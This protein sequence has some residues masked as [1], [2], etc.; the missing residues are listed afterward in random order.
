[1]NFDEIRSL[2]QA[3]LERRLKELP[4]EIRSWRAL[5]SST[6]V[7][8][9]GIHTSQIMALGDMM[10]GL[11]ARQQ[12]RFAELRNKEAQSDFADAYY[13]LLNDV[14]G[15]HDLWRIFRI[16]LDQRQNARLK[17]LADVSDLVAQ[18]CYLTALRR[19]LGWG[20]IAA[21]EFRPPPLT[22][23]E[24]SLTPATASRGETIETLGFSVRQYR[25]LMLPLP[26]VL[27]PVDQAASMWSMSSIAHE[28]GHNLDHDLAPRQGKRLSD[29]FRKLLIGLVD[30][31][32]EPQWRRW[33]NEIFA[34][35]VA[36][37][38]CGSGYVTC[39]ANWVI[40]L[41][42]G[43]AF[44]EFDSR[45]VHPPLFLRL[46]ILGFMLQ[47]T[48]T[49]RAPEGKEIVELCDLQN[50][51]GWEAPYE[52]EAAAVAKL[53]IATPFAPL[54][55]HAIIELSDDLSTDEDQV[56]KL[57]DFFLRV[58][59]PRPDPKQWKN[60]LRAVPAAAARAAA[61]L[62][63]PTAT[64]LDELQSKAA[65]YFAAIPPPEKLAGGSKDRMKELI[66]QLRFGGVRATKEEN[67]P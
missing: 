64:A 40:G 27:Y 62:V 57:A 9:W 56:S 51:P 3:D 52:N 58:Q 4:L 60:R 41:A 18:D 24:S 1:M 19:A 23:L 11:T 61:G 29:E 30:D 10:D 37:A 32:R 55:N 15:T 46:R 43:A 48:G 26:I 49:P 17:P 8:G 12:T 42:P 38:L 16:I 6:P 66:A 14:G 7:D 22:F 13:D 63:S 21:D 47:C 5:I 44:R 35:G 39:M 25:D 2:V 67:E 54:N 45:A 53:V 36:V 20:V 65:K 34:D 59:S 50:R 33:M 31:A 28:V